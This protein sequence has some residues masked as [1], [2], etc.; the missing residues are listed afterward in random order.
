MY[1]LEVSEACQKDIR[2][3]VRKNKTLEDALKKSIERILANPEHFKPLRRPL[4][5]TRRVHVLGSFVLVY[6]IE[7]NIVRLLRFAHHDE[8]YG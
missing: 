4:Q 6:G 1:E 3:L 2:H 7:G 8:A 5:N